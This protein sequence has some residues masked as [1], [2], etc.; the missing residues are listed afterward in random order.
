MTIAKPE[1]LWLNKAAE[2]IAHRVAEAAPERF[3]EPGAAIIEA[4][5]EILNQAA[6]GALKIEGMLGDPETRVQPEREWEIVH[7]SYWDECH[8]LDEASESL[9]NYAKEKEA[10]DVEDEYEQKDAKDE[11]EE[12]EE[13]EDACAESPRLMG[14]SRCVFD[15]IVSIDWEVNAIIIEIEGVV[16]RGFHSLRTKAHQIDRLWPT[17]LMTDDRQQVS[18]SN[19]SNLKNKGGRP[20]KYRDDLLIEIIRVVNMCPDGLPER[21]KLFA[22]LTEFGFQRWGPDGCSKSTIDDVLRSVYDG[23]AQ[24]R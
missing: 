19:G 4:R 2:L 18:L 8:R 9:E 14:S 21:P 5:E 7:P 22:H 20:R 10:E 24:K 6:I 15:P 3:P 1:W 11:H 16:T 13:P 17:A 12:D 23:I